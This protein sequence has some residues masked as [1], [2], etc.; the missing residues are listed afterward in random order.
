VHE[1]HDEEDAQIMRAYR[2]LAKGTP[3]IRLSEAVR[4][5]G[6]TT[7]D[8][9]DRPRGGRRTIT[10]PR[11]AVARADVQFIWTPGVRTDGSCELRYK[12]E[13]LTYNSRQHHRL[14]AGTF[15]EDDSR[16]TGWD[17]ALN[18][19]AMA[20]NIPP[21]RRRTTCA[22]ITCS[23]RPSGRSTGACRPVTRRC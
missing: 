17:W 4:L 8:A 22:T 23:G 7:I 10:V 5:G 20:P 16:K 9:P 19:R 18:V 2:E 14:P 21:A 11:I 6:L 13:Q 15:D 1:R 12:R 3:L